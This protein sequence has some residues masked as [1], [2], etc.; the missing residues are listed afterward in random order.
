[1]EK[2]SLRTIEAKEKFKDKLLIVDFN[3]LINDTEE[4]MKKLCK[5]L[6][7][8]FHKTLNSPSF[9]GELIRS[10]SSFD[11]TSEKQIKK[12]LIESYQIMRYQ[13]IHQCLKNVTILRM[14]YLN[15]K[16][17]KILIN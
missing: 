12:H 3:D 15:I 8:E 17:D 13:N 5:N 11:S 6:K 16:S 9:N 1:M 7:L 2:S 14:M 4:T 10:N